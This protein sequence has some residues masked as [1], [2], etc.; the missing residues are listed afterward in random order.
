MRIQRVGTLYAE[1]VAAIV[2][3]AVLVCCL[4]HATYYQ[5]QSLDGTIFGNL[6]WIYER[7]AFDPKP[8]DV[9]VVGPSR[10]L[11]GIS[12]DRVGR[13]LAT[14]GAP[15]NVTNFSVLAAGRD[16]QW[17]L[18]QRLLKTKSPKA[19]V[20]S[21]D[22][23]P[24]PYGHPAFKYIAPAVAVAAPPSLLLHNYLANLAFLPFRQIKLAIASLFPETFGFQRH[25]SWTEYRAEHV[26]YTSSFTR[27][28]GRYFDMERRRTADEILAEK[29]KLGE[30]VSHHSIL[31]QA[32]APYVE[33][34]DWDYT[35]RIAAAAKSRNMQLIFVY[36]PELGGHL[37]PQQKARYE[38]LGAVVDLSSLSSHANL[39]CD[40]AHFN[41][42][43]AM[44]A[45]D[46]LAAALAALLGS[47]SPE[48]QM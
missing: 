10:S 6:K 33:N 24:N 38:R 36:M 18:V 35:T 23:T 16:V 22:E 31:G 19:I 43:G 8:V 26:D 44:I 46:R 3:V 48:G 2:L 30:G 13:D 21:I 42:W 27:S 45:S 40:W 5:Y 41:H 20:V 39:Y 37:S 25:F 1:L 7:G 29:H 28:D 47:R 32:L 17:V 4:P 14:A 12:A 9:V 11:L 34:D 15:S